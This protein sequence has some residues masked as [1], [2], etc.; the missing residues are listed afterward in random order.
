MDELAG[1]RIAGV[2]TTQQARSLAPR[3][4]FSVAL[5]QYYELGQHYR[6]VVAPLA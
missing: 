3:T 5:E 1:A 4:G 6:D 2:Y